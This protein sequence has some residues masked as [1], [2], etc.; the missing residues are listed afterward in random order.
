MLGN[1][2]YDIANTKTYGHILVDSND[3]YNTSALLQI[4]MRGK[5]KPSYVTKVVDINPAPAYRPLPFKK[6]DKVIVSALATRIAKLKTMQICRDSVD[7]ANI[8][9]SQ[10]L[11]YFNNN[12]ISVEDFIPL[13]DKVLMKKVHIPASEHIYLSDD[14]M[15]V[16]KV[17]KVGDGGF[18]DDWKRRPMEIK[19]GSTVLIKDNVTTDVTINGEE[20]Y[21]TDDKNIIG[22]FLDETID[23]TSLKV[24]GNIGIFNE[25]EDDKI[26]GSFLYKPV[27]SHD[28]DVAQTYTEN[29]FQVVKSET[30]NTDD[31]YFISRFDTEYVRFRGQK[32]YVANNDKIMARVAKGDV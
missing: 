30:L 17:L 32:Y 7:Y 5:V 16:G 28:D 21:I 31:V 29:F 25:Y 15:S 23:L 10:V 12:N 3:W 27:L 1:F 18:T 14:T 22:E 13:Y 6:G 24:Y 11:G 20:Y 9:I 19:V 2:I 26:E 4:N 8:H